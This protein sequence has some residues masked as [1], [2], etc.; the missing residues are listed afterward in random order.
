MSWAAKRRFIIL[1]IVGL[2]AAAFLSVVGIAALYEAPSCTDNTQNQGES[3]IDCGGSCPYLCRTEQQPPTVLF[4]KALSYGAGRTD[5]IASVENKNARAAAKN[6]PYRI[7]LYG[8]GQA[9]VQEVTGML[10]LPPG[11]TVPVYVP[12]IALGKQTVAGVFLDIATSSL[13]WFRMAAADRSVPTVSNT[14]QSGAVNAPRVEAILSNP[15]TAPFAN[16]RT[17]VLVRDKNGD[18]IAASATVVPSIPAQGNATATF[19]W[20]NAFPDTPAA[21]EVVPVIPLP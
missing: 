9:L 8:S 7:T 6:V 19:T 4:T 3:G 13:K 16:V 12:N 2:V 15:T 21:I 20:N 1:L 17:I 10:D 14:T 5:V 18:I 11:T